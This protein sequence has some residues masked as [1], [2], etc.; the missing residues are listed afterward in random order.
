MASAIFAWYVE[1]KVA[2]LQT[3]RTCPLMS[4]YNT[5]FYSVSLLHAD[6]AFDGQVPFS[7]ETEHRLG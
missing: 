5:A 2:E 4:D 3:I 6:A 1:E 7:V